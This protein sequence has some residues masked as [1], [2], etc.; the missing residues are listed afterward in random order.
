MDQTII[1]KYED[2]LQ[3]IEQGIMGVYR[4]DPGMTDYSVMQ[5][6]EA[7]IDHYIAGIIGRTPR[8]FKL[9]ELEQRIFRNIQAMC[10]WRIGRTPL[11]DM[12]HIDPIPVDDLILCLKQILSSVKFWNKENGRQGYMHFVSKYVV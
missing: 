5:T 8:N 12:P 2:V 3:N 1:K 9:G 7:V 10:D 11:P 6:L 4:A